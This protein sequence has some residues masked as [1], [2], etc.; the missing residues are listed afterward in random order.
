[1]SCTCIHCN[2]DSY[3]REQMEITS[4]DDYMENKSPSA[5]SKLEDLYEYTRDKKTEKAVEEI[6][7]AINAIDNELI[8]LALELPT[9]QAEKLL[10]IQEALY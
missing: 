4:K 1:M 6:L 7:E 3:H 9:E 5:Y 8:S 2:G 10:R